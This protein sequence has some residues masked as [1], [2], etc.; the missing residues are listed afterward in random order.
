MGMGNFRPAGNIHH[1]TLRIPHG[2]AEHGL[3]VLVEKG[4][5]SFRLIPVDHAHL[6]AL[7]GEGVGKEIIGAAI[8]LA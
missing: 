2:L 6:N 8:E 4:L 1:V 7:P 5:R 3:G